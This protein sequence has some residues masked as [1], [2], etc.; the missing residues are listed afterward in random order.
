M[1]LSRIGFIGAALTLAFAVSGCGV[2]NRIRAKNELNEGARSYKS[3]KFVEAQQHFERALELDPDQKNAPVFI[4]RSIH[5]QFKPGV[6]APENQE[7][8]RKAIAAYQQVL[9]RDPANDDA[10]NSVAFLYGALNDDT[11]QLDWITRRANLEGVPSEKRA[12]AYTVLASKQWDCSFK[13]TEQKENQKKVNKDD[14]VIIQFQKPKEQADFDTAQQ[15]TARG[16]ELVD[17]ALSLNPNSESAWSYKTN[18]LREGAKL[19]EMDGKADLKTELTDKANEA[20]KRTTELSEE[21]NRRKKEEE[22][23]KAQQKTS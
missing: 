8:A 11:Q 6:D 10:Y 16:M 2:I 17:K 18:L 5:A 12:E 22:E 13:I 15:C 3:G 21:N 14:K 9:Q 23:R 20:Q 1:K 19:A 4:A 7:K